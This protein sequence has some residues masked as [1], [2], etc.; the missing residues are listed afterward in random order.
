MI[1][2]DA[3]Y[4]FRDWGGIR[5]LKG[6]LVRTG[7]LYRSGSLDRASPADLSRIAG[8]G[9]RTIVDLRTRRERS[10]GPDRLPD[11]QAIRYIH[12]P[13][14]TS[15][16]NE[17][18]PLTLLYS[19]L[20]GKI[21][22]LDFAALSAASYHELVTCFQPEFSQIIRLL[23]EKENLPLLIH[24]TA[25]KDRTGYACALIQA[26]LGLP[27]E[28]IFWDYLRSNDLLVDY[29]ETMLRRLRIFALFGARR[30][31]FMPVF[32][33]RRTYLETAFGQ[34]EQDYGDVRRYV[35]QGLGVS[36]EV[37]G[38]IEQNLLG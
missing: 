28:I 22:R 19:L 31:K 6:S 29:R 37:L 27:E 26:L 11:G 36:Q 21:S 5:T 10:S 33:V 34:I 32:E 4:N 2:M 23:A 8:L 16:V 24:C 25:G 12:I 38:S 30:A 9:I 17:D 1:A 3:I 7:L 20:S 15:M 35:C 14:K 18:G 13:L